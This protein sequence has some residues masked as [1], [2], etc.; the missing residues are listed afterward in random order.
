MLKDSIRYNIKIS[1]K[2]SEM[3]SKII[4]FNKFNVWPN[5]K[6]YLKKLIFG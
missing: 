5:I 3:W 6:I 1:I 4:I 2:K